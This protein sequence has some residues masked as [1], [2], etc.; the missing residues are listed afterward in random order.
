MIGLTEFYYNRWYGGRTENM[1]GTSFH[2]KIF[3]NRE[4]SLIKIDWF[5]SE[6]LVLCRLSHGGSSQECTKT[7]EF[8]R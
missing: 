5:E 8:N 6:G 1:T 2:S 3:G 7:Y 4:F